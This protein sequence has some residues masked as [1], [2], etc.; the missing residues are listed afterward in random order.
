MHRWQKFRV[1][2][3]LTIGVLSIATSAVLVRI[4]SGAAETSGVGFS[5]FLSAA[6]LSIATLVLLPCWRNFSIA[7]V[8]RKAVGYAIAAGVCLAL[9][10]ATWTSSLSFTSIAVST[11]LVTTNPI[12]IALLCWWWYGHRPRPLTR[13]GIFIALLGSSAIGISSTTAVFTGSNPLLGN[14]FALVGAWFASLYI[15]FG[16]A[17]QQQGLSLGHYVG[18]AYATAALFLLPLPGLLGINYIGYPWQ[19]YAAIAVMTIVGQVIGHTS[20]NWSLTQMSPTIVALCLLFEP[21]GASVLGAILFGEF[22]TLNLWLGAAIVLVGVALATI[23]ESKQTFRK[24]TKGA[25]NITDKTGA[26]NEEGEDA[27]GSN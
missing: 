13:W 18:I 26:K 6:R 11:T 20:I 10:F 12:W 21:V 14:G 24:L 8:S 17:A 19:V 9:H 5:L 1:S 22:P 2:L 15:L 4:A 3:I 7:T 16:R 27:T 25:S 23:G